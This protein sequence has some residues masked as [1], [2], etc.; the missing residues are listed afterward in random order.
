MSV[1]GSMQHLPLWPS[2]RRLR[3]ADFLLTPA[4]LPAPPV[5]YASG[6]Q[7]RSRLSAATLRAPA[8]CR[9]IKKS[10]DLLGVVSST[11][12]A[13]SHPRAT[14]AGASVLGARGAT[15]STTFFAVLHSSCL[16]RIR[17]DAAHPRRSRRRPRLAR[18]H[19]PH[20]ASA[21][22]ARAGIAQAQCN[23]RTDLSNSRPRVAN[24]LEL[25]AGIA[26]AYSATITRELARAAAYERGPASA[27]ADY[28]QTR[29]LLMTIIAIALIVWALCRPRLVRTTCR[30]VPKRAG[31]LPEVE[32]V[33]GEGDEDVRMNASF[34][35]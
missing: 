33:G 25:S 14:A 22:L 29:G 10:S 20:C 26:R 6:S 13:R 3:A 35:I 23:K 21:R 16:S 2:G 11:S 28:E 4:F 7:S 27:K 15:T 12:G 5:E 31:S 30:T 8:E 34:R 32:D 19:D 17:D 18:P 9:R 24:P 1:H